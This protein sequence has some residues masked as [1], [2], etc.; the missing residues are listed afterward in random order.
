MKYYLTKE[1]MIEYFWLTKM[2]KEK[3]LIGI[4]KCG[5]AFIKKEVMEETCE[6]CMKGIF[7]PKF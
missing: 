1:E 5:S 4:C 6:E 3:K 7:I 2:I